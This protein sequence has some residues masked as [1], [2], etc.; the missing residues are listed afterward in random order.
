MTVMYDSHS[1]FSYAKAIVLLHENMIEIVRTRPVA[2]ARLQP[3]GCASRPAPPAGLARAACPGTGLGVLRVGR[4]PA[5]RVPPPV[6]HCGTVAPGH[7]L[8]SMARA[9]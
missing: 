9:R 7:P 3:A 6:R 2:L 5:A 1:L 4:P 8:A